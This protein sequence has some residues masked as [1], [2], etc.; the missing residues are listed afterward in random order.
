MAGLATRSS[1]PQ[2]REAPLCRAAQLPAPDQPG[3]RGHWRAG[4]AGSAPPRG[5]AGAGSS[6]SRSPTGGRGVQQRQVA[7]LRP[8]APPSQSLLS[9]QPLRSQSPSNPADG[10]T[11]S[12][13]ETP[14]RREKPRCDPCDC[15]LPSLAP[16]LLLLLPSPS[17]R[18]PW[19]ASFCLDLQG[20]RSG[21]EARSPA[22]VDPAAGTVDRGQG[23]GRRSEGVCVW[24]GGTGREALELALPAPPPRGA[25]QGETC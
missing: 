15:P 23:R 18:G 8:R 7:A 9:A 20:E 21:P 14:R 22:E 19:T 2:L 12:G 17:P 1:A 5:R 11:R 6:A 16:A 24:P 25:G 4:P 10:Q 13:L 3:R